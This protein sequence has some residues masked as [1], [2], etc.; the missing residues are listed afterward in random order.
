MRSP[1]FWLG[2]ARSRFRTRT[3]QCYAKT[4][5]SRQPCYT[6][7]PV[8]SGGCRTPRQSDAHP[9]GHAKWVRSP[10]GP[11][12]VSGERRVAQVPGP[13][14]ALDPSL[15]CRPGKT[16]RRG[17]DP[18]V[19]KPGHPG[20]SFFRRDRRRKEP[21]HAS[22]GQPRRLPFPGST[23]LMLRAD[24]VSF[25]YR[26]SAPLVLD[27]VSLA[28][29]PRRS[30]RHPRPERLRQDHAAQDP[31]R[32]ADAVRRASV[33]ARRQADGRAGRRREHRAAHRRRAA[34]DPRAVRLHASST[35]C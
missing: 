20:A 6:P 25:A 17:F 29:A 14:L 32:H 3:V 21:R 23:T 9:G 13:F 19:R 5:G 34:G 10:H 22:I 27:D 35:S 15:G 31:G 1:R 33:D 26:A 24:R 4:T 16:S 11:A 2:N 8:G 18:R 28:I 12:T 30:G 7:R